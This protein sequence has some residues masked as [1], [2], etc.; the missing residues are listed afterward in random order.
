VPL[1]HVQQTEFD[2][3]LGGTF[4]GWLLGTALFGLWVFAWPHSAGFAPEIGPLGTFIYFDVSLTGGYLCESLL[5]SLPLYLLL[6]RFW[7]DG[8]PWQWAIVGAL[9]LAAFCLGFG[10][11]Q[12]HSSVLGAS[13][14]SDWLF[15][16]A[17]DAVAGGATFFTMATRMRRQRVLTT[18]WSG[19]DFE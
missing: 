7:A 17:F 18:R 12:L 9:T 1:P 13:H 8:F 3:L 6:R 10:L 14:V 19:R 5:V 16:S 15:I 4:Y 2:A 11:L